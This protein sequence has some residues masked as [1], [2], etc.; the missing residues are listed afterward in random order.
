MNENDFRQFALGLPDAVEGSHMEHADFR[1]GGKIFASLPKPG[2][3][4]VKLPPEEQ[5]VFL[6]A[7]PDVFT[8]ASGAWGRQGSTLMALQ[9][10]PKAVMRDALRAAHRHV[11]FVQARKPRRS[12]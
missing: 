4:M 11:A 1:V 3:G 9:A 6:R 10:V 7:H 5:E 2:V 12:R 8:P